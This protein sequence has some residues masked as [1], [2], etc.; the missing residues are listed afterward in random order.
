LGSQQGFS[1]I[2]VKGV[3]NRARS[4]NRHWGA[5]FDRPAAAEGTEQRRVLDLLLGAQGLLREQETR[6]LTAAGPDRRG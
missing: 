2:G 6:E 5:G 4:G 1:E 3:Y